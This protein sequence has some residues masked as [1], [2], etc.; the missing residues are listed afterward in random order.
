MDDIAQDGDAP[1]AGRRNRSEIRDGEMG[2]LRARNAEGVAGDEA[3]MIICQHQ[4]IGVDAGAAA[5]RGRRRNRSVVENLALLA[6]MPLASPVI[7]PVALLVTV[8]MLVLLAAKS[9]PSPPPPP[10]RPVIRP[11]LMTLPMPTPWIPIEP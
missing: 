9:I 3:T 7:T 2:G 6:L 10:V 5:A 1:K 11:E 4:R 8:T